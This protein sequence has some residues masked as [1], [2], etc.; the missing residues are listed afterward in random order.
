VAIIS[1]KR[2]EL[3]TP[4]DRPEAGA[5]ARF[6]FM[7]TH[8]SNTDQVNVFGKQITV[9]NPHTQKTQRE[10]RVSQNQMIKNKHERVQT[11]ARAFFVCAFFDW[12]ACAC[13]S[14][15]GP[16][17]F[18]KMRK[19]SKGRIFGPNQRVWGSEREGCLA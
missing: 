4:R 3:I 1:L 13:T 17:A 14:R 12:R 9:Q 8:N 2:F 7:I 5:C 16:P 19:K 6:Y 18:D 11:K 10:W 15:I